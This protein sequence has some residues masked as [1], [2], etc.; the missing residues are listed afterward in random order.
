MG[1]SLVGGVLPMQMMKLINVDEVT[2]R[3]KIYLKIRE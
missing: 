2:W 1:G 3:R